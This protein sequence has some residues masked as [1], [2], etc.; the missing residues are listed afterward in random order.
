M[1]CT[2]SSIS[3]QNP[4]RL[5]IFSQSPLYFQT[6]FLHSAINGSTPYSFDLLFAIK[7]QHLFDFQLNRQPVRI[8]T[9][10]TQHII[11]L[12]RL[13]PR[14]Q[15]FDTPRQYVPD[16]RLA[17]GCRR[18]VIKRIRLF[19]HALLATDFL[20]IS[21]FLPKIENLKFPISKI[22]DSYLPVCKALFSPSCILQGT[23]D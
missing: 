12:H 3:T 16:M 18:S 4:T 19:C 6:L 5:L 11:S 1:L 8:P 17:V 9:R 2:D 10:L 22:Q 14:D 21:L 13:I 15:I 20:N 23:T 7:P